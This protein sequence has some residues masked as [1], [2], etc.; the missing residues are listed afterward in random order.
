MCDFWLPGGNVVKRQRVYN[1]S[2]QTTGTVNPAT[3]QLPSQ[4][5]PLYLQLQTV[6]IE[7]TN[8]KDKICSLEKKLAGIN[9]VNEKS[10]TKGKPFSSLSPCRK[11]HRKQP[12]KEFLISV[13]KK[14][15]P[16]W[17]LEEVIYIVYFFENIILSTKS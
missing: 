8:L 17:H 1:Y 11:R 2:F 4:I 7:N 13:S 12:V 9:P 14:L 5:S 3:Q 10:F 6:L 16:D 15:P